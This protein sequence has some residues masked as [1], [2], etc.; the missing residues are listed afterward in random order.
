MESA[1]E[2]RFPC[3]ES[4]RVSWID[5]S[6]VAAMVA[7]L[8]KQQRHFEQTLTA[9][10]FEALNGPDLAKILSSETGDSYEFHSESA[11]EAKARWV[12]EVGLNDA[13]ANVLS[14]MC[15][16]VE[17]D[18]AGDISDDLEMVR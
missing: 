6:D 11:E 17:Q 9:T 4:Y 5:A 8:L 15:H 2:V 13:R 18:V 7:V 14:E 16:L 1:H 3:I 10:G 12:K